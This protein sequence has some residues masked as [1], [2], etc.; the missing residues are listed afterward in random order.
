MAQACSM[1]STAK[2][3]DPTRFREVIGHF[4][5]GVAVIT[6]RHEDRDHGMT[7]S[8]VC[9]VSLEPPTLLVCANLRA[10]TQAAILAAGAF[11]VNILGEGDDAI[12]ERFARPRSDKFDGLAYRPGSLGLPLLEQALARIEC[13]VTDSVVGGTHRVFLGAV[14]DAHVEAG[15]P[16]AYYRG[17]FG[18][19]ELATDEHALEHLRRAVLVRE[20]PLDEPLM[21]AVLAQQVGVDEPSIHYALT[22]LVAEGLVERTTSG[23]LQVPLDARM[24]DEALEA[25]LVIDL[26]AARMAVERAS[27]DAL[28]TLVDLSE[29]I[30]ASPPAP[31]DPPRIEAHVQ[32]TERFH[33]H[34]I[35]LAGNVALLRAYQQLSLPGISLRVLATDDSDS[36][37]LT[38]DHLKIAR[39]MQR[40]T[41]APLESLLTEHSHRGRM[42]HRRAIAHA[43]GRV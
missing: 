15:T 31:G 43:G 25:K 34:M 21:P 20:H 3:F 42:A 12:A 26:A 39:M 22:R 16:L 24:S 14:R 17:R 40:R 10:P 7:A 41:W 37:R 38:D 28:R 36:G 33:E 2:S 5:T 27:D 35:E 9:S 1:P 4:T 32:A 23:Y 8:A 11:A 30:T 13:E 29:A 19:L 18:R 6:T